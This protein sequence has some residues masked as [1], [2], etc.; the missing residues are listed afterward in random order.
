MTKARSTPTE[1]GK[2]LLREGD[3]VVVDR[4]EEVDERPSLPGSPYW[5]YEMNPGHQPDG[6]FAREKRAEFRCQM[7]VLIHGAGA[8]MR[9]QLEVRV[10]RK[11]IQ[12]LQRLWAMGS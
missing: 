9:T 12:H 2:G 10:E 1:V 3:M 4:E 11:K 5:T 8:G 7:A 6:T